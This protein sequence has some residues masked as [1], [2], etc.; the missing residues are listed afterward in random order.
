MM[1]M[2]ILELEGYEADDVIGTLAK[3]GRGAGVD[4]TSS[5]ATS[6]ACSSWTTTSGC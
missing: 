3:R 4:T 6:T 1:G 5:P 2:P